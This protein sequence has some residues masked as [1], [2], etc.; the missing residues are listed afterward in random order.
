VPLPAREI[1][2]AAP[3]TTA[4]TLSPGFSCLTVA[5]PTVR[6]VPRRAKEALYPVGTDQRIAAVREDRAEEPG[7]FAPRWCTGVQVVYETQPFGLATT[8]TSR[9]NPVKVDR[10]NLATKCPID[11]PP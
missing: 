3:I 7:P 2:T 4:M 10:P 1:G 5:S 9:G 6:R 8:T 11:G